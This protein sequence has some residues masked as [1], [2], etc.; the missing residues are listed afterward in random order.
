M[1]TETGKTVT[2]E[3]TE[4]NGLFAVNEGA[5]KYK[6]HLKFESVSDIHD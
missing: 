5:A 1:E 3:N 6:I 2:V 4:N